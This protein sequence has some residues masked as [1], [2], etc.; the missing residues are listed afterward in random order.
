MACR[1]Y[2]RDRL[3]LAR[4][5][6]LAMMLLTA[7]GFACTIFAALLS[8]RSATRQCAALTESLNLSGPALVPSGRGLRHPETIMP[9]IDRRFSPLLPD[10]EPGPEALL[11]SRPKPGE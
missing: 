2:T 7:L 10:L 4:R 8:E 3:V 11:L 1:R 9:G 5:L 6:L